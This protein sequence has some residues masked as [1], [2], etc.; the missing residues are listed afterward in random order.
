MP[1]SP[2]AED[3]LDALVVELSRDGDDVERATMFRSPAIRSRGKIVAFLGFS[4][5]LILK[6]PEVRIEELIDEGVA[7][8]TSMGERQMREWATLAI[9]P[10]IDAALTGSLPLAR[11]ALEFV[12][13]QADD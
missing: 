4:D 3:L 6:L 2:H 10:D 11:E 12:R 5:H 7:E 8:R 9:A 1:R 13:S